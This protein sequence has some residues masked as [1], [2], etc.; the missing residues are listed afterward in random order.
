MSKADL[1]RKFAMDRHVLPARQR[2]QITITLR[3]GDVHREMAL[4]NSL[5]SVCSALGSQKF[6]AMAGV[7]AISRRGPAN[8][9]NVYFDFRIGPA[10]GT[11]ASSIPLQQLARQQNE[12]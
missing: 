2:R 4:S 1:I 10:P 5:P 8:G 7:S 12:R 3:A 6:L 11:T 9:S